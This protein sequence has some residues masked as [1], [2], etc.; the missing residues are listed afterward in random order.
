MLNTQQ[1]DVLLSPNPEADPRR[2]LTGKSAQCLVRGKADM[3]LSTPKADA[4]RT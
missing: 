2:T 1:S 3:P 4:A